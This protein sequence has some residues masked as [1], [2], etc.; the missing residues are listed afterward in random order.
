MA[1]VELSISLFLGILVIVV[2]TRAGKIG[3]RLVNKMFDRVEVRI[4][5][6]KEDAKQEEMK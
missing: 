5:G 6:K 3:I 1:I 2:C 4:D